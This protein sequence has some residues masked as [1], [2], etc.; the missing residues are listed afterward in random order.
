MSDEHLTDSQ[1]LELWELCAQA[2]A[3]H[4]PWV[5]GHEDGRCKYRRLNIEECDQL[6]DRWLERHGRPVEMPDVRGMEA[7]AVNGG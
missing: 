1:I 3:D 7:G 4:R 5:C 2:A 6:E